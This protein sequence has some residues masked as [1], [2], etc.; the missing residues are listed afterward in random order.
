MKAKKYQKT[1]IILIY[2]NSVLEAM[3][4][5]GV[6]AGI[7]GII[8]SLGVLVWSATGL[9]Q[10]TDRGMQMIA[11]LTGHQREYQNALY[12]AVGFVSVSIVTL[13][14]SGVSLVRGLGK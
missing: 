12:A 3:G 13:A 11:G 4:K 6:I 7:I 1:Q 9:I 8:L 5:V 14:L 10:I 2:Q